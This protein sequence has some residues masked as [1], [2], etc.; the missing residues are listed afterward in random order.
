VQKRNC[1]IRRKAK[2]EE[3]RAKKARFALRPSLSALSLV[4]LLLFLK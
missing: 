4:P 1:Q 2:R 3:R